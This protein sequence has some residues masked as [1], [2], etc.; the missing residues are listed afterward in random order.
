MSTIR[1]M[2]TRLVCFQQ[3]KP[4]KRLTR[5]TG[6][7]SR[8]RTRWGRKSKLKKAY[9]C[10]DKSHGFVCELQISFHAQLSFIFSFRSRGRSISFTVDYL[11]HA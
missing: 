5:R 7:P 8:K 11:Q 9:Q 6:K 3:V 2:L 10:M 4:K 1:L